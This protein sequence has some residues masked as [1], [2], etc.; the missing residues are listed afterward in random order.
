MINRS[1]IREREYFHA[2][3]SAG[4]S[5]IL[6]RRE[7]PEGAGSEEEE[8]KKKRS[9]R[10]ARRRP[11]FAARIIKKKKKKKKAAIVCLFPLKTAIRCTYGVIYVFYRWNVF[12]L[13]GA[14]SRIPREPV[15]LPLR[16]RKYCRFVCFFFPSTNFWKILEKKYPPKLY[17]ILWCFFV[18]KSNYIYIYSDLDDFFFCTNRRA[19][20]KIFRKVI[21]LKFF[22]PVL[23][24]SEN[25]VE[26]NRKEGLYLHLNLMKRQLMTTIT[27]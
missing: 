2:E 7:N 23:I 15:R 4:M 3:G 6:E 8:E 18:P 11:L 22:C 12:E 26:I 17:K 27:R 21:G 19:V 24:R 10:S 5:R 9:V 1:R 16:D 20:A 25:N 13:I 14:R